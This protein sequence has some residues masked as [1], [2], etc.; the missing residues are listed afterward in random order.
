MV[1][2]RSLQRRVVLIVLAFVFLTYTASAAVLWG[3]LCATKF[4]LVATRTPP[5][6][7]GLSCLKTLKLG[8]KISAVY[9]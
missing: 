6:P 2:C 8:G 4:V 1:S 7:S 3:T 5:C 9:M